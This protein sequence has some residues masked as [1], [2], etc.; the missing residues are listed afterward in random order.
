MRST[1]GSDLTSAPLDQVQKAWRLLVDQSDAIA[2]SI[3][4]TL[5]ERDAEIYERIGPDLRV[6]VRES[7][8]RHIRRGL[9][10]LAGERPV[11]ASARDLWR[12]TGRRRARQGVPLELVLN[13]YTLG[14]RVLWEALVA[15]ATD[16]SGAID[17]QVL[18]TAAKTVWSN[19][20]V[21][22]AVLIDAYR[23]ESAR[24]HRQDLQ[25]Q[26]SVLDALLEGR[27]ADPE[28][29]DGARAALDIGADDAVACVVALYDGSLDDALAPA[30]DR[31]DRCGIQAR[32][33][34]R[35]GVYFGLLSGQLPDEA[36]LVDLFAPYAPGRMGVASCRDGIAGFAA[37]FQLATRAAETLDRG[38]QQVVSVAERLPEVLLAGSPQVAP[39]LLAETLGPVLGQPEPQATTLLDTLAA[40]LRHD[41]SPTH[42]AEELFCH[43]NTV[44]YRMKQIEQLTGRTVTNPRDKLLLEL[45]LM[46]RPS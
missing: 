45:A 4:L 3:T 10:V 13:A 7:T 15:R 17:E 39:L 8:R 23:R 2:D 37:A 6:D 46:L 28:F 30:E 32:W 19:L 24:L 29:A 31:L 21:Q 36:G 5:F 9:E 18:L 27:G 12:E 25:R 44:I 20:D 42:A 41:G 14:A 1:P 11:G 40:V 22:N 16:G 38:A 43:R 26:Q 33:H 34:V 35:A